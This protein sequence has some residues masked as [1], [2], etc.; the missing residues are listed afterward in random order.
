MLKGLLL[1]DIEFIFE[2]L[3]DFFNVN[4]IKELSEKLDI[5]P[6]TVSNWKQRSSISA[7]K[8]R[9]REVGIYND[10]FGGLN[11]QLIKTNNGINAMNNHGEQSLNPNDTIEDIDPATFNLFK[12]AYEKAIKKDDLK[13]LRVHLM[14]Y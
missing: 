12:E 4:S 8:K 11:T 13:G 14:D 5:R 2:K 6:S 10:I 3:F 1:T 7:V 9:C